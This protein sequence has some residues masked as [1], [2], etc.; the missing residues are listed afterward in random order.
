LDTATPA[1]VAV[2]RPFGGHWQTT[3]DNFDPVEGTI[4]IH[5]IGFA[6][7][8]GR[9][10]FDTVQPLAPYVEFPATLNA[11]NGD[12]LHYTAI[13]Y[14]PGDGDPFTFSG[15]LW[16]TGGTGRFSN[17]TGSADYEGTASL[18]TMTGEVTYK[19]TIVF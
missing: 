9:S 13:G 15:T 3:F 2:E 11:A 19:G 4:E 10:T 16:F 18:V 1:Q 12:E 5:G 7:Y 6:T 17:A 14:P 8:L